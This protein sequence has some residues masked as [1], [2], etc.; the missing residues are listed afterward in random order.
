[1][2]EPDELLAEAVRVL[3]RAYRE[4]PSDW[5]EFVSL[6]TAGAAANVGG[7]ERVLSRR[8][9]SWEADFCRQL[10]HGTVGYDGEVLLEHRTEP[11]HVVIRPYELLVDRGITDLYDDAQ[12][13]LQRRSDA[14]WPDDVD[15]D[16]LSPEQRQAL[17]AAEDLMRRL[18]ELQEADIDDYGVRLAAAVEAAAAGKGLRV[19]LHLEMEGGWR[20]YDNRDEDDLDSLAVELLD[21]AVVVTPLPGATDSEQLPRPPLERLS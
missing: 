20:S 5:A 11:V 18:D 10:L 7:V 8:P 13:Q 3:T 12:E 2:T 16:D 15:L 19:P 14:A 6:A 9:G 21:L 4:W 1:M 17:G